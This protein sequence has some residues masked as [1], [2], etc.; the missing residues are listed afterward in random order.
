MARREA[1]RVEQEKL[2]RSWRELEARVQK[3]EAGEAFQRLFGV[4]PEAAETRH[5]ENKE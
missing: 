3:G 2:E 1:A 4:K 5:A